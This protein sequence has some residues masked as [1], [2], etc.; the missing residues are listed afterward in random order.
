MRLNNVISTF[1][2]SQPPNIVFDQKPVVFITVR[3]L[4]TA[5]SF[6]YKHA[7]ATHTRT[8]LTH[9]YA[10]SIIHGSAK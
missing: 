1:V 4:Y 9:V 5:F 10:Y 6:W 7:H 3:T 2:L 8:V